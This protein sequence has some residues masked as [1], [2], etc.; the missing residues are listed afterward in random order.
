MSSRPHLS[1][2]PGDNAD[3]PPIR[4]GLCGTL[5]R[6]HLSVRSS[7]LLRLD[8]DLRRLLV[9]RYDRVTDLLSNPWVGAAGLGA[10]T[11][12]TGGSAAH[13]A[14]VTRSAS[15]TLPEAARTLNAARRLSRL[16][17]SGR[18]SNLSRSTGGGALRGGEGEQCP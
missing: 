9:P 13:L 10:L 14:P 11:S 4:W 1:P 6:V 16:G 2:L 3:H 15:P 5:Y 7:E 12:T 17:L 18:G 8:L